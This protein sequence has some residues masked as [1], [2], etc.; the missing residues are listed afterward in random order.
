[1]QQR[2]TAL[3]AFTLPCRS[4]GFRCNVMQRFGAEANGLQPRDPRRQ[5]EQ[6]R[7]QRALRQPQ[8]QQPGQRQQ[9]HRVSVCEGD[10]KGGGFKHLSAASGRSARV[11]GLPQCPERKPT[12]RSLF[13]MSGARGTNTQESSGLVAGPPANAP[14]TVRDSMGKAPAP[15]ILPAS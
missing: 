13:P 6:Q 3:I 10:S 4:R 12:G 15:L 9:Q 7:Q 2:M 5:L 14:M 11:H 1:M 8:Q